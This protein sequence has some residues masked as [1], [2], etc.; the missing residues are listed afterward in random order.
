MNRPVNYCKPDFLTL[1]RT[2]FFLWKKPNIWKYQIRCFNHG[3]LWETLWLS[4]EKN[5]PCLRD[6]LAFLDTWGRKWTKRG[7]QSSFWNTDHFSIRSVLFC[8]TENVVPLLLNWNPAKIVH[9]IINRTHFFGAPRIF[10]RNSWT[11]VYS[12]AS[13]LV[14]NHHQSFANTHLRCHS[15]AWPQTEIAGKENGHEIEPTRSIFD[16]DLVPTT[17]H[18]VVTSDHGNPNSPWSEANQNKGEENSLN[19]GSMGPTY[20][21]R[22]SLTGLTNQNLLFRDKIALTS[23]DCFTTKHW[24][25]SFGMETWRGFFKF[26]TCTQVNSFGIDNDISITPFPTFWKSLYQHPTVPMKQVNTN[27]NRTPHENLEL[28][29][30]FFYCH[31]VPT[32]TLNTPKVRTIW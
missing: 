28:Y 17:K 18:V 15:Q 22:S 7:I 32:N 30:D 16:T 2:W 31:G 9:V 11:P 10:G 29:V 24:T 1:W 27:K 26:W 4:E 5:H 6:C 25:F 20:Y 3:I 12:E 19:N 13:A 14:K 21:S 23:W 8:N